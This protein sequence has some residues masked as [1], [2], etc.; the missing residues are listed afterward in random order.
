MS[1]ND[2]AAMVQKLYKRNGKYVSN[3]IL[4]VNDC[5]YCIYEKIN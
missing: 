1:G 5:T 4:S 3:E 2:F